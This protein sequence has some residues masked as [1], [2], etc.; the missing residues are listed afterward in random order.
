MTSP[1]TIVVT[2][3]VMQRDGRFLIAQRRSDKALGGLWE[4]PGGK[5]ELGESLEECLGR[6]LREEFEIEAR[7]GEFLLE[8]THDYGS[9]VIKLMVYKVEHVS[10]EFK[11]SEHDAILWLGLNE[12]EAY[13]FSPADYPIIAHLKSLEK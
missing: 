5:L 3:A 4:F 7:I 13:Q 12:L 6:E 8:H 9:A 10:G 1:K 2:A 11:L